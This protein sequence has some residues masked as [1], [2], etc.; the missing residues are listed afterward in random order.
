VIRVSIFSNSITLVID[1]SIL[2]NVEFD[3]HLDRN[4]DGEWRHVGT[5]AVDSLHGADLRAP[6]E[7]PDQSLPGEDVTAFIERF[8]LA[9]AGAPIS[10]VEQ[11]MPGFPQNRLS[12]YNI[13]SLFQSQCDWDFAQWAKNWG[14]SS[15]A[16]TELLAIEGV[17]P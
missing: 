8:P 2:D 10:N 15:T 6:T 3:R 4:E 14:P 1:L 7:M 16:V 17:C 11:T 5:D 13:W 9:L 12:T